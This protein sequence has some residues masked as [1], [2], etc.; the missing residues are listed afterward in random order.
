MKQKDVITASGLW[1]EAGIRDFPGTPSERIGSDWMLLTAGD[2]SADKSNWNTLTASWGALG[3]L[4][5]MDVAIVFIRPSRHTFQFANAS[6]FFT[7]SFFDKKYRKVLDLCSSKS[8]K[9]ID[10]AGAAGITPITFDTGFAKGAV[11]FEEA[12]EVI[13][14]Q[15]L[16]SQD[17]DP[18]KI[19]GTPEM[20]RHYNGK[21]YH[22]MFIGKVLGL[23][24]KTAE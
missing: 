20:E 18:A 4:W 2:V 5:H 1:I 19:A 11:G 12:K 14:C 6:G 17:F 16:Y 8:G 23:M 24:R 3:V 21:D 13:I 9:D 7:M 10:K 22:R 15:K